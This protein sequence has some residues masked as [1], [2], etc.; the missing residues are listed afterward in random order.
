[1]D[2]LEV[3]LNKCICCMSLNQ[4]DDVLGACVRGIKLITS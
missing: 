4:F 1:M 2:L 3:L